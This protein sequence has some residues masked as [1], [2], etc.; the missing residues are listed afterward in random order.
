MGPLGRR[1]ERRSRVLLSRADSP[2][3]GGRKIRHPL[4]RSQQFHACGSGLSMTH[5]A[6]ASDNGK[7]RNGR[8]PIEDAGRCGSAEFQLRRDLPDN[9][10]AIHS[11][12][13]G[14]AVEIA[15]CV[16]YDVADRDTPVAAIWVNAKIVEIGVYPIVA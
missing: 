11:P 3:V 16:K 7:T 15:V 14:G 13:V 8:H 12:T 10:V 2:G 5:D 6:A 4:R 9:A 1:G